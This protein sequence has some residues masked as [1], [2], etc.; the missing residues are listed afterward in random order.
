M[1][2]GAN[3]NQLLS[4]S[5]GEIFCNFFYKY[6]KYEHRVCVTSQEKKESPGKSWD[7]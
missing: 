2:K 4:I 3:R 6:Q 1:R 5:Y 7:L